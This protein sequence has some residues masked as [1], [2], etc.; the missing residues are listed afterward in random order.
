[1]N[2][3]LIGKKNEI[4][5]VKYLSDKGFKIL[6]TNFSTRYG[7]I[8]IIAQKENVLVFVEVRSKKSDAYGHAEETI[9]QK[10]IDRI[11]KTAEIFLIENNCLFDEVRFDVIAITNQN[12]RHIEDAF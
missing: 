6:T 4:K 7:E 9:T 8:D 11:K 10:K 5:A 3:T 12:L 2:K 1:M